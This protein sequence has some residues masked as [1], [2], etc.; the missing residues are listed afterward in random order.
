MEHPKQ[1]NQNIFQQL[2]MILSMNFNADYTSIDPQF[3]ENTERGN[4]LK[5]IG[6]LFLRYLPPT[7]V[8][9][10]PVILDIATGTGILPRYL[11]S[12]GYLG[13]GL[14][15][16]HQGL[17]YSRE[18][19]LSIPVLQGDMNNVTPLVNNSVDGIITLG[20]NRF[21]RNVAG[22][23]REMY[24]LMKQDG[25]FIWPIDPYEFFDW[26][27]QVGWRQPTT[28]RAVKKTLQEVGFSVLVNKIPFSESSDIKFLIAKK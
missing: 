4:S 14:D 28:I 6:E 25:V 22:F 13:I 3:L 21:I 17:V 7:D 23:S 11:N 8:T 9:N 20:A 19:N 2:R 5:T 15:L 10:K 16:W 27:M 18:Q 26:K 24:R 12:L 1:H